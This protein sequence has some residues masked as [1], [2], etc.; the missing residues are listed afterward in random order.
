V[1]DAIRYL[2]RT[3]CQWDALPVDFPPFPLVKHYF[4][5]WTRDGTLGRVHNTLREQV[6]QAEGRT[7]DSSAALVDSQSLRAAETVDRSSRGYDGGRSMA[8]SGTSRPT[9]AA[10]CWPCWSP[11]L[12]CRTATRAIC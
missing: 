9:P 5:V 4:T 7:R 12:E 3:G 10:G 8:A 2:A 1:V 6:R 11:A